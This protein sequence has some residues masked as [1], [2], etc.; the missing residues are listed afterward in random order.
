M[1]GLA[2]LVAY[3]NSFSVPFFFDDIASIV[4]NATIRRLWPPG[5]VLN[6]PTHA[7]VGGRLVL[8][9]T[10]AVN[11]ALGGLSVGGYHAV[12]LLIHVLAGLTLF[13]IVRR[14]LLRPVLSARVGAAALPLAAAVAL[15]WVVHPVQ[16]E[17]VT[18]VSQRAESLMGLF[19]LLTLYGFIR[20]AEP[21]TA[22][23]SWPALT[24]GAC[25][26]GMA[27]KEIMV[28][29]P[30]VV[31]LYDRTF[32]AGSFAAAWR[33][34]RR[35]Y[36]AL[37]A[38]WLVLGSLMVSS[39]LPHRGV[40]FGKGLSAVDYAL[41]EGPAVLRYLWLSVWPHPLV[42]DYGWTTVGS[43]AVALACGTV[44]LGLVAGTVVALRR[45]PVAGFA[46]AWFFL[47]L[48]PTSSVVPVALQPVA[49]HRLYLP[50]A[51]LVTV[52]VLVCHAAMGR[53]SLV[54]GAGVVLVL[55]GLTVSRNRD[56]Q[57]EIS[58]WNQ[59][60]AHVPGNARAQNTLACALLRLD[61][62][63]EA[64]SH[65]RQAL[66]LDPG[67]AVYQRDYAGGLCV[68]GRYE[69]AL[70]LAESSLRTQPDDPQ[71]LNIR[72]H[73]LTRLGRAEEAIA[74]LE[75]ALRLEP[76]FP[77]AR[78]N[79]AEAL[80]ATG[81]REEAWKQF[82]LGLRARPDSAEFHNQFGRAL[83]QAGQVEAGV[84]EIEAALRLNP[85]QAEAL[86]NLGNAEFLRGRTAEAISRYEAA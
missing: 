79:L 80:S 65:F 21:P 66:S 42:V 48:A 67:R 32:L 59:T 78:V 30:L 63:A 14:T 13:G 24:V 85:A 61:R 10:Y 9:L 46:G 3:A 40:G 41:M 7:G 43:P 68:L 81:R 71:T 23:W 27:T 74:P 1:I 5:L 2:A 51:M 60:L 35:L 49:E 76:D 57:T 22:R 83:C 39:N 16:T 69:A 56:Y 11:H 75:A 62:A 25:A 20:S 12:N 29:A 52:A 33:E 73:A 44:V 8:N 45:W 26:L 82:A 36:Q 31:L 47:I 4:E 6:P 86:C 28:T 58:I 70:P 37:A 54:V 84:R 55:G 17:S 34:R 15:V 50:L 18:Y 64:E 53:R 77:E 72:G 38:T 19:Y